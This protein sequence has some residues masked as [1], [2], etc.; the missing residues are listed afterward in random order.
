MRIAVSVFVLPLILTASISAAQ[1]LLDS[2]FGAAAPHRGGCFHRDYSADH[3]ARHPDQRVTSITLAPVPLDSPE[4]EI[5]LNV[6]I[7]LRGGGVYSSLA[8]CSPSRATLACRMEGDAGTFTLTG[9][10]DSALLL[11]VGP[12]GISFEGDSEFIALEPDRGDDRV[13]LIP[14]VNADTC[15]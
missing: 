8:Y 6:M 10:A 11:N 7:R 1:G 9:A 5:E 4:G 13:F 2:H 12:H 14:N 3:L 15:T